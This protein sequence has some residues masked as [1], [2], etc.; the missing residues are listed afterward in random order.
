MDTVGL[1][2]ENLIWKYKHQLDYRASVTNICRREREGRY[3]FY[4]LMIKRFNKE[5]IQG[6]WAS[7]LPY[8]NYMCYGCGNY[9]STLETQRFYNNEIVCKCHTHI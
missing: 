2:C 9:V 8:I 3:K 1:D 7:V 4:T 6:G 5:I